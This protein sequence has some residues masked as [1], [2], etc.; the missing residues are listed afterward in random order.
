MLLTSQ[1]VAA[2]YLWQVGLLEKLCA[3]APVAFRL[4]LNLGS[5]L[6]YSISEQQQ[7]TNV[8]QCPSILVPKVADNV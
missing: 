7:L 3:S 5:G 4:L 8:A 1:R 2:G 6:R